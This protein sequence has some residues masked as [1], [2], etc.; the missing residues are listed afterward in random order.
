[1]TGDAVA[2][3]SRRQRAADALRERIEAQGMTIRDVADQAGVHENSI[4]NLMS[5]QS[6]PKEAT[7]NRIEDAVRWRRG[8]LHEL[9]YGD[10]P[11]T[12]D[13]RTYAGFTVA[14]LP[15]WDADFDEFQIAEVKARVAGYAYKVIREVRAFSGL[16]GLVEATESSLLDLTRP[17]LDR[18]PSPPAGPDAAP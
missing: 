17:D 11:E 3:M 2:V 1:M 5:G 14:L 6:W 9:A 7:R 12:A 18:T 10:E 16:P 4:Y 13:T 8:T 15:G